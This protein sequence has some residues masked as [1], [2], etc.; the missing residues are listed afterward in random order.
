MHLPGI[1]HLSLA[2]AP[3]LAPMEPAAEG[4]SP[5]ALSFS[6]NSSAQ[7]TPYGSF[8][9]ER[10]GRISEIMSRADGAQR[11]LPVPQVPKLAVQDLLGGVGYST[12]GSKEGSVIGGEEG[13][14]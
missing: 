14:Y 6:N 5:Y 8:G 1:R 12:G 11:K 13:R 3:A 10:Q 7:S 2:H 4:P 9:Q